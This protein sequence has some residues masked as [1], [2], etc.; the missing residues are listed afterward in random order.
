[1]RENKYFEE[2]VKPFPASDVSW[3]LQY[4]DKDKMQGFAVPYL[5]AR[6]VADRLDA[7]VGQHNW[8]DK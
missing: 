2:F 1:M 5:D 6:A 8:K 4:V 7:V 3:R